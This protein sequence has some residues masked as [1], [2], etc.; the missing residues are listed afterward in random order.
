VARGEATPD[1]DVDLLVDFEP[2]AGA[3][4]GDQ[5]ELNEALEDLGPRLT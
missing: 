2:G 5:L 3:S 1:S 4:F